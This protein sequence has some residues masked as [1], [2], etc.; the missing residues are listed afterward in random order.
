[1]GSICKLSETTTSGKPTSIL[2]TDLPK[3]VHLKTR[4]NPIDVAPQTGLTTDLS[5]TIEFI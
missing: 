2:V 4:C 1:M 3:Q 5:T